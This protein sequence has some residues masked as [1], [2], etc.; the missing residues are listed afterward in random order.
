[1]S[2]TPYNCV[3]IIKGDLPQGSAKQHGCLYRNYD[4]ATLGVLLGQLNIGSVVDRDAISLHKRDEHYQLASAR[5]FEV[6]HP[7]TALLGETVNL[8]GV[9]NHP[10]VWFMALVLY[11][12]AK[13]GKA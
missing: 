7:G 11:H 5:H 12:N 2:Y 1:V 9:S 10:N 8:N 13:A 6:A 4:D 3:K